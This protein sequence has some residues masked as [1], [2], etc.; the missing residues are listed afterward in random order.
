MSKTR[1][2]KA[3]QT[4]AGQTKAGQTSPERSGAEQESGGD[5]I[6]SARVTALR[7]LLAQSTPGELRLAARELAAHSDSQ[8]ARHWRNV[9]QLAAMREKPPTIKAG[10]Q[11]QIR[12][13]LRPQRE[14]GSRLRELTFT[15]I[16]EPALKGF[17]PEWLEAQLNEVFGFRA[18]GIQRDLVAASLWRAGRAKIAELWNLDVRGGLH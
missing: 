13:L 6:T 14:H 7:D 2:A 17:D 8:N 16:T 18:E 4:K 12:C 1:A 15:V 11:L 3:D 5:T 10:T 9:A